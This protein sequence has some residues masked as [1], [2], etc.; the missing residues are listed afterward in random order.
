[1]NDLE[2]RFKINQALVSLENCGT[3]E[4]RLAV[5]LLMGKTPEL[6]G[7]NDILIKWLYEQRMKMQ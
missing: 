2:R 3:Q 6:L 7:D 4:Y 1:M 5:D